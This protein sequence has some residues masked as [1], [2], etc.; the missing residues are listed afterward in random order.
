MELNVHN[1]VKWF[2]LNYPKLV[3]SMQDCSHHYDEKNLN[4]YHLEGDVWAHTMMVM[5]EASKRLNGGKKHD[6]NL[7]VAALLHD[8]G[9]PVVRK[10]N[11]EKKRVHFFSHEPMSAFMCIPILY[12]IEKD[13]N[14]TLDK[15]LLVEVI[16]IHTDVFRLSEEELTKRLIC[17]GDLADLLVKLAQ[18]DGGGRFYEMGDR[19]DT[20]LNIEQEKLVEKEKIVVLNIGIPCSGKSTF[21]S[22][23]EADDLFDGKEYSVLCRDEIVLE[24]GKKKGAE[25]YNECFDK[26][27]HKKV[28]SIFAKQQ[29][30]L[31]KEGKSVIIDMTNMG[32]KS[33]RSTLN[34]FRDYQKIAVVHMTDL[35]NIY[36]RND[37]RLGKTIPQHVFKHMICKF[38][39]PMYD[40]FDNI[41]WR[42]N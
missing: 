38:Q 9:K 18:C 31:I 8:I 35:F 37:S 26:I 12:R 6:V 40:E 14:V 3:K 15:R 5:L 30:S 21:I 4:P 16:S 34:N 7:L 24:E 11:E 33:R 28:N 20:K 27:D 2:Q 23:G 22:S 25:T 36:R 39:P 41:F 29:S 19:I 13:F 42:F 17:N 1:L 32:R 10:R